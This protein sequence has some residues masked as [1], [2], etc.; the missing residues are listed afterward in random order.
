[1]TSV[2]WD[3]EGTL[4]EEF[5]ESGATFNCERNVQTLM[6]LKHRVRRVRPDKKIHPVLLLL[7]QDKARPHTSLHTGEGIEIMGWSLLPHGPFIP[8]I[9]PS[10]FHPFGS[11]KEALRGRR[12]AKYD[13]LKH[14]V[15]EEFRRFREEFYA[16][17]AKAEKVC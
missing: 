9:A 16:P 13:E 15:R 7:L 3:S 6:K 11:L 10:N 14:G 17:H 1:M 8:D 4:S 2:F 12:F 5:L